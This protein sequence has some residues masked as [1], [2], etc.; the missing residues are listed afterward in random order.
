MVIKIGI[1]YILKILATNL[2]FIM[3]F[4]FI[5]NIKFN[6]SLKDHHQSISIQTIPK[7][8]IIILDKQT[9][10]PLRNLFQNY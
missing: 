10:Q 9:T 5:H 3:L 8:K 7:P 4:F 1:Y 2:T 6:F